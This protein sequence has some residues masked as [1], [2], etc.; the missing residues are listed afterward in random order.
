MV[1]SVDDISVR[2]A[3]EQ[4]LSEREAR[5]RNMF[6][7]AVDGLI[8]IDAA[9]I[10]QT[11][12]PAC[13]VIFGYKADEVVGRNVS[14]LMPEPYHSQHDG[15]LDN[16][17]HT[18][19]AAI[20]GIGREVEGRRKDGSQFP[21][22]LSISRFEVGGQTLFSGI[23]RDITQRKEVERMKSEF[24]SIVSHE[25]RTPL[26]SIR[27]SLGLLASDPQADLPRRTM[28][29]LNI[30]HRNS[31]RL[32]VLINDILDVDK[33]DAGK[34]KLT[35]RSVSLKTVLTDAVS[36]NSAYAARY[37]VTLSLWLEPDLPQV[38]ADPDRL[39]QVM[40]NLLSNASKFTRAGTSVDIRA[41]RKDTRVRISVRDHGEGI[42]EKLK[43]VIFDKFSQGDYSNS[44]D[45]TGTGLGLGI[46]R[47][48]AHLM[49]GEIG[50]T[51]EPGKGATFHVELP[52]VSPAQPEAPRVEPR[53]REPMHAAGSG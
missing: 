41:E 29:L 33:L 45:R 23:V 18:G 39:M 28:E 35:L 1:G 31:E 19:R 15:Y 43:A 6:E 10:V 25:L 9:G 36:A 13:E 27:G 47:Q 24:I 5:L 30:A 2:K 52:I 42:P 22:D 44:R 38:T 34:M 17:R 53:P 12:N 3:A 37:G 51:S 50:F 21:M 40:A 16:Y 32:V 4:K 26:T 14:M 49:D 48:I 46:A 11:Y 7:H 8:T 20:I